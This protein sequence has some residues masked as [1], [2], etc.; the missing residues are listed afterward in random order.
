MAILKAYE[1]MPEAYR[2]QFRNS[3]KEDAQTYTEFAREK[4]VQFDQWCTYF[5]GGQS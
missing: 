5:Q 4:Q 3:H 1:L 2:Q